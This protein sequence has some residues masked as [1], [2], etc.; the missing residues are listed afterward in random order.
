M[1]L[2]LGGTKDSRLILKKLLTINKKVIL[3]LTTDFG[4]KYVKDHKNLTKIVKKLDVNDMKDILKKYKINYIIDATH[5]Y[6]KNVSKNIINVNKEFEIPL[7]RYERKI[8]RFDFIN[9]FDSYNKI[10]N[11][12]K[13][14]SENIFF[15]IGS[16]NLNFFKDIFKKRNFFIRVLPMESVI[17]KCRSLNILPKNIIAMQGPFTKEF[18]K[19]LFKEKDIK[20]LVT[21]ETGKTGGF[22]DKVLAARDL[23]I[24]VI[25]LKKPTL[26]FKNVKESFEEVVEF[27]KE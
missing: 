19:L 17:K 13:N 25:V 24:E 14:K 20:Y 18:N 23:N 10:S 27:V 7:V 21:K 26:K 22:E 16:K 3:T 11:Y 9:Y 2:L 12:L 4:A 6:A 1:I 15:A 5:P 8:K